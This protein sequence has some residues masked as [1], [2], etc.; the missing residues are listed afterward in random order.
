MVVP[1]LRRL[2]RDQF[3]AFA[4]GVRELIQA[5]N[6]VSLYEYAMHRLLLRHLAPRKDRP[7]ARSVRSASS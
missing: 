6:Q 4:A 3:E 7:P 1:T 2:S 5:D